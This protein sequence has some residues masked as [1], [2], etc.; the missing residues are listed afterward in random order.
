MAD[1]KNP[2]SQSIP[3]ILPF[4]VIGGALGYFIESGMFKNWPLAALLAAGFGLI[5]ALVGILNQA[6]SR[7]GESLN[8]GESGQSDFASKIA[9][10]VTS[11]QGAFIEQLKASG[12]TL[13]G[14][15]K[16]FGQ[17]AETSQQALGGFN[18]Q[19][20]DVFGGGKNEMQSALTQHSESMASLGKGWSDEIHNV[21]KAHRDMLQNA[22][23]EMKLNSENWRGQLETSLM[24]HADSVSKSTQT[25]TAS[26]QKISEMGQDIDKLLHTQQAIDSTLENMAKTEDFKK[27]IDRLASHLEDADKVLAQATK[28]RAIRL[29]EAHD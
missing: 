26:L 15:A 7:L 20:K 4:V 28:P 27:V 16:Q 23:D 5:G 21:F 3:L 25:L 1:Q 10:S 13:E 6:T 18:S 8:K 17:S 29:V 24:A 9:D 2:L 22:L 11:A 14:V 19:L 12:K